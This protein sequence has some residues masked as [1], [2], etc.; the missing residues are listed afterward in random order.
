MKQRILVLE[1]DRVLNQLLTLE[2]KR[3]GFEA[4]GLS[5]LKAARDWLGRKAADLILCDG[6]IGDASLMEFLPGLASEYPI[7]ILTAFGSVQ[8]AVTAMKAG[9][10]EYLTKPVNLDELEMV[11][12]R[13]LQHTAIQRD[14]QYCRDRLFKGRANGMAGDSPAMTELNR[15]IKAVAASDA[16]VPALRHSGVGKELVA[17]A[18]HQSS[19]RA[20]RNFVAVDCCSLQEKLFESELFGH[21]KGAFTGAD[22]QKPGLIDAAAGGTLFLDEIGEIEPAIQAKLLRVLET[23]QYRRLGGIKDLNADVRI[24]AATNRDLMAMS[25][26]GRFRADLYYRLSAFTLRIP[27]LRE[28]LEDVPALVA[29]FLDKR[30][31]SRHIDKSVTPEAMDRLT[32]YSYPGNIRELRNMLE[33]AVILSGESRS[34]QPEHFSFEGETDYRPGFSMSFTEDPSL[35]EIERAYLETLLRKHAGHRG[36]IA[37]TL[38]ISERSIYRLLEKHG[39]K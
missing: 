11:V 20:N 6:R 27:P 12:K 14:H 37:T 34:I 32:H 15:L 21:E 39:F 4:E 22:R 2:L 10:A 36:R 19:P 23:G 9:A 18:I 35:E 8:E 5:D 38:G 29:H 1:D 13:V 26:A 31:F 33:R 16:T 28:R 3:M 30:T 25:T 24:V 7:I 17:Q